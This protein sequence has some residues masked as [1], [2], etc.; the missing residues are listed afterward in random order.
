VGP[1]ADLD[2]YGEG[3]YTRKKLWKEAN[4]EIVL[5]AAVVLLTKHS[6]VYKHTAK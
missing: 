3:I 1:R 5:V 4:Y 2:V 6:T